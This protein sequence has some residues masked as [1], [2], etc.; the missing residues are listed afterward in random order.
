MT[1]QDLHGRLAQL[2]ASLETLERE[3]VAGDI[4]RDL[5]AEIKATIDRTRISLWAILATSQSPSASADTAER[6]EA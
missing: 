1:D 3:A 6:P 2:K 5:L 4:P